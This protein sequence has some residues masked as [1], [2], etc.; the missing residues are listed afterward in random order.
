MEQQ[1]SVTPAKA[2]ALVSALVAAF[3]LAVGCFLV[4]RPFLSALLWAAILVYSTWPAFR[5]LREKAGLSPGW[6]AGVM[7]LAEF[8]LIGVPLAFAAPKRLEDVEGLRA[9]VEALLTQGMPGL[10]D[11]LGRLPFVGPYLAS[12]AGGVDFGVTRSEEHTSEL[13]SRQYLVCRLLLE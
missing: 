8:L 10:G 5:L 13:Q 3:G 4:L 9:S 6:A 7:V 11:W 1:D 2:L 12:W